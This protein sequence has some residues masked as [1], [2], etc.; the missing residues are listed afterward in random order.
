MESSTVTTYKLT[1]SEAFLDKY[2]DL[3]P[4]FGPLGWVT[5]KRTYARWIPSENR[6][7]EWW[8]TCRRVLEGNFNLVPCKSEDLEITLAEMEKAYDLMFRMI[9]LPPG[10]GL[11]ISGTDSARKNGSS[12]N[13]CWACEVA[14]AKYYNRDDAPVKAST[15]FVFIMDM[16]MMGGGV[17]T[18]ITKESTAKFNKVHN[19]VNLFIVCDPKHPNVNELEAEDIPPRNEDHTYIR[20]KD[21]RR[22]WTDALRVL[23]D[24]HYKRTNY[25]YNLVI[26]VSDVRSAGK[27]IKG[28]GGTSAGPGPLVRMLRSIHSVLKGAEGRKLTSVEVADIVGYIGK[29]VVSGNVRRSAIL[30]LFSNNDMEAISSKSDLEKLQD[31]R[32]TANISMQID[33]EFSDFDELGKL[34]SNNGEPGV[35]NLNRFQNYGRFIDGEQPN[36][37]DGVR[38][39]NPCGEIGLASMEPCNLVELFPAKIME[40]GEDYENMARIAFRYSKRVTFAKHEWEPVAEIIQQNRRVGV[41]I[42]G[43]EDWKSMTDAKFGPDKAKEYRRT[44][45]DNMYKAIDDEDIKMSND[46]GCSLSIKKTTVKPSGS[47]SLLNGS[48]PGRHAH[49]SKYYKRRIRLSHNDPL[50]DLLKEAGFHIEDDFYSPNTVVVEFPVKAL[51]A[52]SPNFKA[53]HDYTLEEQ[54]EDQMELQTYWADNSVSS[55]L[56]FKEDEAELIPGM[57]R[58]YKFKSTSMLPYVG[59]GYEQ[60]PYEPITEKEYYDMQAQVKFWPSDKEFRSYKERRDMEI[61]GQ[62][63]CEGGACPIK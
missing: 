33:D 58:K 3:E 2:R 7:E 22:G 18:A 26:D 14:P 1:F 43:W 27:R 51:T 44:V 23:I 34:I 30:H 49:Y 41:S 24:S 12:L 31:V 55:T 15:P 37:D 57:L 42:S 35:I 61:I 32:W 60:A 16:L 25:N 38:T 6:N 20:V 11:W 56:T 10:R 17:G 5:Y 39:T 47:I 53:A 29:C 62:D 21:S 59:H 52:D 48:S 9:W 45:L 28:F 50:I 63:D 40:V 19:N 13:N 46:L 4:P 54:C 36:I 8:E